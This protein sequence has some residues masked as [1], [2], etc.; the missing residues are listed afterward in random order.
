MSRLAALA[1]QT[2]GRTLALREGVYRTRAGGMVP[3]HRGTSAVVVRLT[4]AGLTVRLESG[5]DLPG[6]SAVDIAYWADD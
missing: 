4:G 5:D 3:V 2:V 6:V 1:A